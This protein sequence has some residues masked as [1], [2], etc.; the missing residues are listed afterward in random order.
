MEVIRKLDI[1]R[2]T[3]IGISNERTIVPRACAPH[4]N[5]YKAE[6][7]DDFVTSHSYHFPVVL[8]KDGSP[9]PDAN[10]YFLHKLKGISPAKHRTLDSIARDLVNFRRWL[11][12]EEVDYL[13]FTK[14][15]LARPTYLYCGYLHDEIRQ[16]KIVTGTAKRRMSSIAL[17]EVMLSL[18]SFGSNCSQRSKEKALHLNLDFMTCAPLSA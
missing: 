11:D 1:Y 13:R 17:P 18:N 8:L 9:W 4:E 15:V 14:R 12:E 16:K 10:R 3:T 5:T 7:H 2:P 6:P